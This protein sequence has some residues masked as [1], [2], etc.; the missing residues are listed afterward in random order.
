MDNMNHNKGLTREMIQDLILT[1]TL[2][3]EWAGI[4]QEGTQ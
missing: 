1:L 3:L 4:S 2:A